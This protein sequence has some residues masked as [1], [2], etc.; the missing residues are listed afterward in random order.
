VLAGVRS[1]VDEVFA[2]YPEQHARDLRARF[3]SRRWPEHAGAW[4]ELYLFALFRA[5]DLEVEV[6]PV[7]PGVS[8][9]PDFRVGSGNSAFVVEARLVA[10]GIVSGRPQVGRDEWI[11]G[12]LDD[13]SHPNF[14]VAVQI[15]KRAPQRPRRAAV[16][17]GVLEWLNGLDPDDVIPASIHDLPPFSVDAGALGFDLRALPMKPQAPCRP[18]RRLVGMHPGHSG[19]D[20]TTSAL[21]AALKEKAA[22]YGRPDAR[23]YSPRL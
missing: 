2:D 17:A 3:R 12:P 14:M 7:L 20:T 18:P 19:V 21:R 4:W 6:H 5:L 23:S 9:R 10:A 22:K 11:T 1:F 16:T 8:T 15:T 13:L